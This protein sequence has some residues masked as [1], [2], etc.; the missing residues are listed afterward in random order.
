ME[1]DFKQKDFEN[2]EF[3]VKARKQ[4]DEE[5]KK[6]NNKTKQLVNLL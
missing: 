4:D 1:L 5:N 6:N 2:I 3:T